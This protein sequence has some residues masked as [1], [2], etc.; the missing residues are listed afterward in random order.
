MDYESPP[1]ADRGLSL[2]AVFRIALIACVFWTG[3]AGA[4]STPDGQLWYAAQGQSTPSSTSSGS[5][6]NQ[7]GHINS[8]GGARAVADIDSNPIPGGTAGFMTVGLDTASGLYFALAADGYL[9]SGRITNDTEIDQA[10]QLSQVQM[11]H[12]TAG[13][14]DEVNAFAVDVVNHVLYVGLYGQT[15]TTSGLLKVKYDP[16]T[17]VLSSP[18]DAATATITDPSGLLLTSAQTTP[19]NTFVNAVGM[20]YVLS[21]KKL[22]YIDQTNGHAFNGGANETWPAT[23]GIFVIDMTLPFP[24]QPAQL[25][26]STSFPAGDNTRYISGFAVDTAKGLIYFTATNPTT[27][28]ASSK[29]YYIPIGG[30]AETL[31]SMPAGVTFDF[32]TYYNSGTNALVLDPQAQILY[33]SLSTPLDSGGHSRNDARII[34]LTLSADGKSFTSGNDSFFQLDTDDLLTST[35]TG[36]AFDVVP[37]L[38]VTGTTVHATEQGSAINLATGSSVTDI[39]GTNLASFTVQITGGTFASNE[40]SANDDHL[41]INGATSGTIGG[42]NIT[43]SYDSATETLHLTG[44]DTLAHYQTALAG[45]QYNATGNNPTNYGLNATRTLTWTANDGATVGNATQN[46]ATTTLTIDAVNDAPSASAPAGP[47]SVALNATLPI[48]GVSASDVDG[49]N[50]ET[51]TLTV[52]H[53]TLSAAAAGGATV[54]GNGT[55]SLTVNGSIAA[56]NA[57]LTSLAYHG[58]V[59][60]NDTLTV[61][62]NDN[63]NTGSGGPLTDTKNVTI[64]VV[65]PPTITK[66]F[67]ASSIPIFGAT[68]LS[69]QLLNPAANTVAETGV[70]FTDNL[71]AGLEFIPGSGAVCGGTVTLTMNSITLS[72]ATIPVGTPCGITVTVTGITAGVQNNTTGAVSSSNGGT[73]TTSNT[74]SIIV[75]APPS[76]TKAFG[77]PLIALNATTT[78]TFTVNNP[79]AAIGLSGVSFTDSFPSGL[80]VAPTPNV[81]SNCNGTFTANA[82]DGSVALSG[83]SLSMSGTCTISVAVQG[84][85]SGTKSNTAGAISSAES[86]TGATSNTATI[87]VASPPSLSALFGAASIPLNQS[88]T[89]SFTITNSNIG[90]DFS[91]L[92]FSST[93][94]SGLQLSA[95]GNS[96]GGSF[97]TNAATGQI[98]LTGASLTSGSS[99]AISV[100]VTGTAAGSYPVSAGA[101]SDQ[102][103]GSALTSIDVVAPPTIA[104]VFAP[105]LVAVNTTSSLQFTLTNPVVN[106][107]ALTG[108]AFTDTL[109]AGITIADTSASAC[110]GTL[111]TTA[112]TA[113]I[114]LTGATINTSSQ[115]QFAINVTPTTIGTFTNVTGAVTST[116]GGT[117]NTATANLSTQVAALT[118][119]LDDSRTFARYGQVMNYVLTIANTGTSDATD[120]SITQT[121]PAQFDSAFAHWSCLSGGGGASCT[122]SGTGPL[123]DSGVVIPA[124]RS[125]TWLIS[126]PILADATGDTADNSVDVT[127][128]SDPNSPHDVVD[129]DTLVVF[130]DGFDVP[131]ADGTQSI[132]ATLKAN[133]SLTLSLPDSPGKTPVDTV[134]AAFSDDG[135]G[136]RIERL[137]LT[138]APRVR[139][140]AVGADGSERPGNWTQA[141]VSAQL[142]IGL[143]DQSGNLTVVLEST[144]EELLMPLSGAAQTYRVRSPAG[145]E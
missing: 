141:G 29:L 74:A 128:Q 132:S 112:A 96:C 123:I 34:Q 104:K 84:T 79:N 7:V 124:S 3:L 88:T 1:F 31:M 66:G 121:L 36:M 43:V 95:P 26:S 28:P 9:R 117:G 63:G 77:A 57:T 135:S 59:A 108:V 21:T 144:N 98:Q 56:I 130:R 30:G 49:L 107:V 41:T 126:A 14:A 94:P 127:S 42:T 136:F 47:L 39:D 4:S 68:S 11:I 81:S 89:L 12:G 72:G 80:T 51:A 70:A 27:S 52:T 20:N 53:G 140:V 44:D 23:N 8:D 6:D 90:I 17:G 125:I 40:T 73:G 137:N 5:S 97:S 105:A 145:G 87:V 113:T 13:N 143:A 114:A 85:S 69:F 2:C 60:G 25:T 131:Y 119:T 92:S 142:A 75:V 91:G 46:V 138:A 102:G 78:L 71:P 99:C 48:S 116:N 24:Q 35:A 115:C 55:G 100:T 62:I 32:A 61:T 103:S 83:G 139:I 106:T 110:G 86:G 101:Q 111:T 16:V 15:E 22:Y 45:V 64:A 122:A 10:S 33:I 120:V 65:A 134:L 133:Q 93:L 58:L 37:V 129:S 50:G 76:Y 19:G 38:S 118:V 109:P 18:Y 54:G 82:G 67:G